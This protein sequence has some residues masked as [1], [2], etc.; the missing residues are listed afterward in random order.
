M[1]KFIS[2]SVLLISMLI[3]FTANAQIDSDKHTWKLKKNSAGIKVYTSKV[4]DSK[5]RAVSAVTL[6]KATADS[7]AA[8]IMDLENCSQWAPLCKKA[9]VQERV[10]AAENYVYSLNDIPFPGVDRD[11]ITHVLWSK[12]KA[13]GVILMESQAVSEDSE[14]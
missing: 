7:V 9:Y 13:T 4:P 5:H 8:L 3:G 11:A 12:D 10:S 14:S 1:N 6:I 2:C